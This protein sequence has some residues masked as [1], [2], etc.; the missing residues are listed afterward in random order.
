MSELS[1]GTFLNSVS[2]V[3]TSD[4]RGALVFST[5]DVLEM[6]VIIVH[7]KF[8]KSVLLILCL[9]NASF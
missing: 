2:C 9:R 8:I 3:T 5:C 7:A 4:V 1:A 6:R